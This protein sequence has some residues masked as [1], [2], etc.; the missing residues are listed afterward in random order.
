MALSDF[1]NNLLVTINFGLKSREDTDTRHNT[2]PSMAC[3]ENF[4]DSKFH[5]ILLPKNDLLL[6]IN[7]CYQ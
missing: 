7:N 5:K 3:D 4:I 2:V 6:S 1:H